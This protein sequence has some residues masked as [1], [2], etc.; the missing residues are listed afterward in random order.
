M[1]REVTVIKDDTMSFLGFF[2]SAAARKGV[3]MRRLSLTAQLTELGNLYLMLSASATMQ[4]PRVNPIRIARPAN[5]TTQWPFRTISAA[6]GLPRGG[7]FSEELQYGF[8]R[9]AE[10]PEK[11]RFARSHARQLATL[12]NSR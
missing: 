7:Q 1:V 10:M 2:L 8:L 3:K 4:E 11:R 6:P 9:D 12:F 5:S